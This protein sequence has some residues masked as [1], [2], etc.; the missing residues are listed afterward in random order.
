MQVA[1]IKTD[2][3]R[4]TIDQDHN[5]PN[6]REGGGMYSTVVDW[7]SNYDFGEEKIGR[8][9]YENEYEALKHHLPKPIDEYYYLPLYLLDHTVLRLSTSSFHNHWDSGQVGWIY[10]HEDDAKECFS[11]DVSVKEVHARLR[12]EVEEMDAYCIG[13][14]YGYG[15]EEI[16]T[17]D[18][19]GHV[20]YEVLDGCWGFMGHDFEK[21]GLFH[22]I[23]TTMRNVLGIVEEEIEV[24]MEELRKEAG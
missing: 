2:K 10:M 5:P 14:F 23:E 19:C 9:T 3:Y 13:D 6:P 15:I 4:V 20:E 16:H 21:N 8:G 24:V 1:K 17:C 7:H 18:C 22:E 12:S 11:E